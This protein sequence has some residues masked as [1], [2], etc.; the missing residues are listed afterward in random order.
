MAPFIRNQFTCY[1][2][3]YDAIAYLPDAERLAAYDILMSYALYGREPD[4]EALPPAV[5]AVYTMIRPNVEN[6]R[7]KAKARLGYED[8]PVAEEESSPVTPVA[9][10]T[11]NKDKNKDKSKCKCKNNS[12]TPDFARFWAAY[13]RKE[14]RAEAE[15][16][17]RSVSVGIEVLLSALE[18]QKRLP[19]WQLEGGRYIPLP[20]KWLQGR[21]WEDKLYAPSPPQKLGELELQAIRRLMAQD[22]LPQTRSDSAS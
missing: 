9:E 12:Y 7:K 14:G 11:D 18:T 21:R 6:G 19:Q 8:E 20:A 3:F 15:R 2:S 10:Q 1:R 5:M 22:P 4:P 16:V 13:P 17:F